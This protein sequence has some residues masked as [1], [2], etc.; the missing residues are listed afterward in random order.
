MSANSMDTSNTLDTDIATNDLVAESPFFAVSLSKLVIMSI[1]TLGLYEVYWFY[2][3]WHCIKAREGSKIMP[4]L[5]SIFAVLYCYPCFAQ[6]RKFDIEKN[7]SSSFLAGPL[8]MGWIVITLTWKLPEPYWWISVFAFVFLIPVQAHANRLNSQVSPSHNRNSSIRGWNWL[9]VVLGSILLLLALAGTFLAP[10]KKGPA[11]K[12]AITLTGPLAAPV[13]I[14]AADPPEPS[15]I[16]PA[17]IVP[18]PTNPSPIVPAPIN[19]API[20]PAPT[21]PAPIVPSP[22]V[23]APV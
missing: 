10:P 2:R 19:P 5:R 1:C 17:P 3:N 14:A 7:G 13:V 8:A 9:A 6:L 18:A 21:V 15:P 16:V 11:Q 22:I 4:A 23:P 20:V 12:P